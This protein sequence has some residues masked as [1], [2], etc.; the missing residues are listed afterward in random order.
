MPL[1]VGQLGKGQA[2]APQQP[3]KAP[4]PSEAKTAVDRT[5]LEEERIYRKGVVTIRDV[6]S[7]ASFEVKPGLKFNLI[8]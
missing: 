8:T 3:P 2:P 7:P 5:A 4:K 1:D 6:I